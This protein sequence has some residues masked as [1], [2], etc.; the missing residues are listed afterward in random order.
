MRERIEK[1]DWV[2]NPAS[3][4]VGIVTDVGYRT[5]GDADEIRVM[6]ANIERWTSTAL[7]HRVPE[8]QI[9]SR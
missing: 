4:E 3:G 2:V 6:S 7:W 8:D 1:G 9:W 5:I